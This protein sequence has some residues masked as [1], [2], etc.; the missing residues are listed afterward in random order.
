MFESLAI[1]FL[2]GW[3]GASL[4]ERLKLPRLIG[5]MVAGIVIGP[6]ALNLLSVDLLALGSSLR[7][8]ALIVILL[9]AGLKLEIQAFKGR[10]G[11]VLSWAI[12]PASLEIMTFAFIGPHLLGIGT[13]E[14]LLMGIV[15]AAVSPAIMVPRLLRLMDQGL[16]SQRQVPARLVLSTSVNAVFVVAMFSAVVPLLNNDGFDLLRF[17]HIPLSM[18]SGLFVG[19]LI[20]QLCARLFTSSTPTTAATLILLALAFGLVGL[21]TSITDVFGFS[22]YLGIV[23]MG[24]T[25]RDQRPEL[26]QA[27]VR[28]VRDLW[29]G[30]EVLLFVLV[31]VLINL[32]GLANV[33]MQGSLL[34]G[35][36][37]LVRISAA[38]L[39][40][41]KEAFDPHEKSFI[42]AAQ[43][44]KATVQAAIAGIPLSLG[45]PAG[46]TILGVAVLAILWTA[47]LGTTLVERWGRRLF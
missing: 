20:G 46:A 27:S 33:A 2:V 44:P 21:E 35:I 31:G 40:L 19:W 9:N 14:A 18:G 12:L 28:Q 24:A 37:L 13:L 32:S 42:L 26:V 11:T 29:V 10:I 38:Y 8:F 3:V 41:G 39:A 25:L 47:P 6:A 5:M 1:V 17:L 4:A 30:A 43:I 16:G 36:A 15:V 7:Q 34:I 23:A 45:L 22:G